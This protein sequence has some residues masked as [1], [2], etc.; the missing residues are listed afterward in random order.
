VNTLYYLEEWRGKQRISPPGDNFNHRG[1]ISPLGAK[2][3]M[4]LSALT[5]INF[6]IFYIQPI[7]TAYYIF[8]HVDFRPELFS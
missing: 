5:T 8:D 4:G 3:R 6:R 7:F 1:Q 2:L